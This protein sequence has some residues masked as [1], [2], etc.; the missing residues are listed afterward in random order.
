MELTLFR[1]KNFRCLKAVQF[2]PSAGINV[3]RGINAQGKTSL[4][5]AILYAST[6]KSHRTNSESE[7]VRH[8]QKGFSIRIEARRADRELTIEARWWK[9]TK[10]LKV[11]DVPQARLSD[12]LGRLS[13]V[14]F[15]PEDVKLVTGSAS[16]RRKFLDMELSQLDQVYLRHLQLYRQVLRQRNELLRTQ[17]P[18]IELLKIWE[19]QLVDHG[20]ALVEKR[21][22]YV[23]EL[24]RYASKA[25]EIIS[26]GE[27]LSLKFTPDVSTEESYA[28][29]LNLSRSNDI[30]RNMTT[31]GPHRDDIQIAI[32]DMPAR[33]YGSQG[34]QKSAAL[35]I[36]LAELELVHGRIREYPV[37][38][39][40]E[41]LSE[42]DAQRAERLF[43]A[44]PRGV[45]CLLT[46]TDLKDSKVMLDR[47]RAN[48]LIEGGQLEK[49]SS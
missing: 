32:A 22:A 39:L 31:R 11:N 37:L 8:D 24:N 5:E 41:V 13:I 1:C 23:D 40:D 35:A 38:M 4:L 2:E 18:D 34:Q 20:A 17:Q 10:R 7:L 12:V 9:G 6:S 49:V 3:I 36:K 46:T 42:L 29:V 16:A 26:A 19:T 33:N 44:I 45:Q 27:S 15:S 43:A 30:R 25:Y 48:F 28:D 14:L 21:A 47:A